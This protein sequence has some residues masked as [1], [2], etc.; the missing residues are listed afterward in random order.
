MVYVCLLS[1]DRSNHGY[2]LELWLGFPNISLADL[3]GRTSKTP[4]TG[5]DDIINKN[6]LEFFK[7]RSLNL[8]NKLSVEHL[9][10]GVE[11]SNSKENKQLTIQNRNVIIIGQMGIYMIYIIFNRGCKEIWITINITQLPDT[12]LSFY[13]YLKLGEKIETCW[14]FYLPVDSSARCMHLEHGRRTCD[15]LWKRQRGWQGACQQFFAII[16]KSK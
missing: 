1:A 10:R 8:N 11:Q 12:F 4:L 6:F 2:A 13:P 7:L 9:Y 14:V 16:F 3:I 15:F 5:Q